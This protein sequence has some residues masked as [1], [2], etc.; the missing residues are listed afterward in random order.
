MVVAAVAATALGLRRAERLTGDAWYD[1]DSGTLFVRL[2]NSLK[3]AVR[4]RKIAALT[5]DGREILA[6]SEPRSREYKSPRVPARGSATFELRDK[7]GGVIDAMA[8]GG[9]KISIQTD[10]GEIR[11]SLRAG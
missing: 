1:L 5:L 10:R 9:V 4:V 2:K 11:L 8:E 3:S 7:G 6:S